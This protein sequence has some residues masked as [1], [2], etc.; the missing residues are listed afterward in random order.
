[1]IT[2]RAWL[3]G[4]DLTRWIALRRAD[5]GGVALLEGSYYHHGRAVPHYLN[6]PFAGLLDGGMLTL[7]DPD[8][9]GMR[10]VTLTE[11]GRTL[12]AVLCGKCRV[13]SASSGEGAVAPSAS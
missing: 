4:T 5:E 9:A 3:A 2:A 10:A 6:A 12:Y 7:A 8:A 11:E 1:M 13:S